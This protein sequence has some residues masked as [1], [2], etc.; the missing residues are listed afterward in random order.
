LEYISEQKYKKMMIV[1]REAMAIK[2]FLTSSRRA[3][4]ESPATAAPLLAAHVLGLFVITRGLGGRS[5]FSGAGSGLL[6]T[7]SI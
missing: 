2:K 6:A 4:D 1:K 5:V 7:T 3:V